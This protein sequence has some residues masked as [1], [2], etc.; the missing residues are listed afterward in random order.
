MATTV[1][2]AASVGFV[3]A[4]NPRWQPTWDMKLSTMSMFMNFSGW[5]DPK[6]A[7]QF[8]VSSFDWSNAKAQWA[9]QKPMDCEERLVTQAT[10]VKQQNPASHVYVYRNLVKALPWYTSVR[11]KLDD[12]QYSGFFLK[13]KPGGSF[14]NGTY[15]VPQCTYE[16][17]SEFYHDQEQTPEVPTPEKPHPDGSCTEGECDCGNNPCGEYLWDHRNG[18]MLREFLI[19]EHVLGKTGIGH[20]DI[21]GLFIDDFWCSEIINGTCTDP[22]QGASE[23]DKHQ[24]VDMGLSDQDILDITNEWL[25]TFTAVQEAILEHKAYTWSIIPNQQNANAMPELIAKD[26]CAK[27][28]RGAIS[29]NKYENMPLLFGITANTTTGVFAAIKQEVAAFQLMRGPYAWIGF[30]KWGMVWP[31][32]KLQIPAEMKADYGNPLGN[33]T[34]SPANVFTRKFEK[35]TI[36]LNCNTYEATIDMH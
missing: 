28:I 31:T 25:T 1:L 10:W 7:G 36:T 13:F 16:K 34:E 11:E 23:E 35:S 14:P 32:D 12:P 17:C 33:T 20:P 2:A 27:M 18:T 4:Q 5:T 8:G 22:V 3:A 26:T 24:Q 15:H 21:D 30:G 6:V 19:N 29:T 9:V